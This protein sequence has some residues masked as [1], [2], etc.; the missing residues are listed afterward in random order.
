MTSRARET[1]EE[2][3]EGGERVREVEII[4]MEAPSLDLGGIVPILH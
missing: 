4:W 1:Q 3:D 2:G